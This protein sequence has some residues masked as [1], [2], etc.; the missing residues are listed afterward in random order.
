VGGNTTLFI[1]DGMQEICEYVNGAFSQSYV[2]GSYIDEPLLKIDNAGNKIYYHANN[3]YSVAAL[4]DNAGNVVE[5]YKYDPYGK[6]TVLAAD[7]VTVRAQSL[8]GNDITWEGRRADRETNLMY[9]RQRM[10]SL[11]LGI[12]IS[13]FYKMDVDTHFY[14]FQ[15]N[16]PTNNVDPMGDP[17]L[18]PEDLRTLRELIRELIDSKRRFN[19]GDGS[20]LSKFLSELWKNKKYGGAEV[21]AAQELVKDSLKAGRVVRSVGLMAFLDFF[22]CDSVHAA[23]PEWTDPWDNAISLTNDCKLLVQEDSSIIIVEDRTKWAYAMDNKQMYKVKMK[24]TVKIVVNTFRAIL[25]CCGEDDV[26]L[27]NR[28]ESIMAVWN[29]RPNGQ[30]EKVGPHEPVTEDMKKAIFRDAMEK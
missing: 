26:P 27:K 14:R 10:Y 6:A 19:P 30:V 3:L 28:T 20:A 18:D 2:Y 22:F 21:G 5:R 4:T 8:Y 15:F 7:G 29:L 9:F 17:S 24:Y 11:D 1:S 12:F 16:A 23:E 13:R 25:R